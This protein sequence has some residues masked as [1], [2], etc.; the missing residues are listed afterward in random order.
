MAIGVASPPARKAGAATTTAPRR[1]ISRRRGLI[2]WVFMLP[3]LSV[4][5]L[6][7]LGPAVISVYYSFTNWSGLGPAKW[8]GLSNYKQLLSDPD[9]RNGLVHNLYWT[10]IFLT[11]PM[12]MGLFG[13]YLLSRVRRYETLFRTLFFVPYI[14]ATVV[15][16]AIWSNLLSPDTG[17]GK[18]LGINFL[19]NPEYALTSVAAI[20]IWSW[21]GFV[22]VIFFS[23]M[24]SVDTTLYEAASLDGASPL[25]QYF[26]VTLPAIRPTVMFIGLMTIVWSFLVFDYIFILTK[27]G[28][29]GSTDVL[30]TV[31]YRDAFSNQEA[32]YAAAIGIVI[33]LISCAVVGTYMY[34]RHRRQWEI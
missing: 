13:A 33:S 12:A 32:G 30:S 7:I 6:V 14:V 34:I 18:V 5:V 17:I 21:W 1:R 15:S 29:A 25:R 2:A 3:L 28:P 19:G 24:R 22:L 11:V 23:A 9:F 27:G 16:S 20:N 8:V 10:L 31:L 4:N 26:H